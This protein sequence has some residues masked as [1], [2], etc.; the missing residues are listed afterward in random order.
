MTDEQLYAEY[1]RSGP[2]SLESGKGNIKTLNVSKR[3]GG[4]SL[5]VQSGCQVECFER[6]ETT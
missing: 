6:V 2:D 1:V 5:T 3:M 4:A